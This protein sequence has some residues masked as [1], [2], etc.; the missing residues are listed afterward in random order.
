MELVDSVDDL[1]SSCS[2]RGIQMPNFE[3]FDAK[4]ASALNRIIHNSH[5]NRRAVY[6]CNLKV[7]QKKGLQFYQTQSNTI[8][9]YN[10]LPAICIEKGV[11]MKVG[12]DFFREVH[13]SQRL[14]RVVLTPNLQHGRQDPSNF[15]A[16]KSTDHQSEKSVKYRETCRS[17]LEET[18]R[19]HLEESQRG[20]YVD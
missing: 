19:K 5:F 4:I 8:V 13:E 6:W 3:V 1:K 11:Y 16:R 2:V 17:L 12:E 7:A 14:P 10:T 18:R 15:E 9:L 20:K